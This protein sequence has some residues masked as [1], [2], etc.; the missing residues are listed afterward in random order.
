MV[1]T[2][3]PD[4]V[5]DEASRWRRTP[6]CCCSCV[7]FVDE[8]V[9]NH[10]RSFAVA[11]SAKLCGGFGKVS[12]SILGEAVLTASVELLLSKL[13]SSELLSFARKEQIHDDL[14]KW[15]NI[16]LK[17]Y[18][19][20]EDAEEKQISN[21]F[22]KRWLIDLKNLA[23]DV[24][25]ILDEFETKALERKLIPTCCTNLNLPSFRFNVKMGSEIK[26]ITARF[27]EIVA[28]KNDLH[29]LDNSEGRSTKARDQ[30]LPTTSLNE[31]HV[32]GVVF[33]LEGGLPP[34]NLRQLRLRNLLFL[35]LHQSNE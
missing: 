14:K 18:A 34:T 29:L 12:M 15:E 17:I 20:L 25:D 33:F 8:W 6:C 23:Y 10:Q 30:R 26:K 7:E 1:T 16:L 11:K 3:D 28:Q 27:Q 5:D 24:E 9:A 2:D 4:G 21:Q 31:A 32:Y 13:A 35:D 19:V 22:V